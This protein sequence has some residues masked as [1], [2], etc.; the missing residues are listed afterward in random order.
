MEGLTVG[1][2]KIKTVVNW[3]VPKSIKKVKSFLRFARYYNRI[4]EGFSKI[5]TPLI[6]L[7]RKRKKKFLDA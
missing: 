6:A 3:K 1:V 5:R 2:A 4:I 7:N